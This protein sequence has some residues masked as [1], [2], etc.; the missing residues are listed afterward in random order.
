LLT[1]LDSMPRYIQEL[2]TGSVAVVA[3]TVNT[4]GG[5]LVNVSFNVKWVM[6]LGLPDA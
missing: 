5:P 2:P 1:D 3:Y 6:L 4:W